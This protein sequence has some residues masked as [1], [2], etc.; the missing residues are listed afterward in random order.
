MILAGKTDFLA[1]NPGSATYSFDGLWQVLN[2]SVPQF[3]SLQYE[4]D[5]SSY[6]TYI[7]KYFNQTCECS[8]RFSCYF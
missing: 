6:L 7:V 8:I 2:F 4:N 1:L 3:S 5:K